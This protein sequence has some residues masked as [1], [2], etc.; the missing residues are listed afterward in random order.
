[1]LRPQFDHLISGVSETPTHSVL[2]NAAW[3]RNLSIKRRQFLYKET[4]QNADARHFQ[5]ILLG[6]R[7][8]R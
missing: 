2:Q 4:M 7:E 3:P 6:Q 1:M 5:T 8:S